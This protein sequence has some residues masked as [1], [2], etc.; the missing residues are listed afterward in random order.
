MNTP[1]KPVVGQK[2]FLVTSRRRDEPELDDVYVRSVGR[3][4]FTVCKDIKDGKFWDITFHLDTWCEKTEYS[5]N[6]S[7]Y[8]SRQEYLDELEAGD[9]YKKIKENFFYMYGP[10]KLTL[11]QLRAIEKIVNPT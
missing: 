5:S 2:L 6:Y 1:N 10:N 11:A 9:L 3:K 8:A 4:Y 7:L